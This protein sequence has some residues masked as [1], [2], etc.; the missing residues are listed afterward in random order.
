MSEIN[1]EFQVNLMLFSL[2][3]AMSFR[4]R[5]M[6][7]AADGTSTAA[8]H[9]VAGALPVLSGTADD[10]QQDDDAAAPRAPIGRAPYGVILSTVS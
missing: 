3:R 2:Q 10:G 9:R 5:D 8:R 4:S 1:P 6:R 7:P